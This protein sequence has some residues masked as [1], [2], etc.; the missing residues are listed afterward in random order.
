[1]I[2][3][4]EGDQ[5]GHSGSMPLA[6][7]LAVAGFL[8]LW[9]SPG[10]AAPRCRALD[11]DT[12]QCGKE[13]IRLREVYAAEKGSPGADAERRALQRKLDSGQVRIRRHGKDAYGRTLGDVYVGGRKVTQADIGPRG[14]KGADHARTSRAPRADAPP[15]SRS[16]SSHTPRV[17]SSRPARSPSYSGS[18]SSGARPDSARRS[19]SRPRSFSNASSG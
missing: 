3:R 13:R 9:Q 2:E 5:G 12:V 15:A 1:M 19:S 17:H 18:R 14:G 10:T 11:G 6:L 7:F 16:P 8:V 4:T